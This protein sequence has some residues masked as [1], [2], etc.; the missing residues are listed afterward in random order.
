MDDLAIVAGMVAARARFE[1][2]L[3]LA[4]VQE[5]AVQQE[6]K[7]REMTVRQEASLLAAAKVQRKNL[8]GPD[9]HP[10]PRDRGHSR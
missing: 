3:K 5:A 9:H 10:P 1:A 2:M 7:A 4:K 8:H 6:A